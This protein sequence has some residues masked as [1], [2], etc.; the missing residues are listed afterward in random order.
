MKVYSVYELCELLSVSR[1]T[2]GRYITDGELKEIRLGNQIRVKEES[3]N[4]FFELKAIK[5][6]ERP[7]SKMRRKA[8][9]DDKVGE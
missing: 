7:I 2:I 9:E 5:V 8:G 4:K 6:K 3:L 1:K